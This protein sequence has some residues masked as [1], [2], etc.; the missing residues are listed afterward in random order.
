[1][2]LKEISKILKDNVDNLNISQTPIQGSAN[3]KIDNLR[4]F[5]TAI[6]NIEKTGLFKNEI[7]Q[8][9][10]TQLYASTVDSLVTHSSEY[11][12]L[13]G[14]LNIIK[15]GTHTFI[16]SINTNIPVDYSDNIVSIKLP[17]KMDLE[18]LSKIIELLKKSLSIP[19]A[20]SELNDSIEI[21][22]FESGSFWIDVLVHSTEAVGLIAAIT[23]A[24]AFINKQYLEAKIHLAYLDSLTT[25]NEHLNDL[26]EA[27]KKQLDLLVEVEAQNLQADYYNGND[28]ERI[29][30]LIF[31]IESMS[32]LIEKGTEVYP[33]L[34][35]SEN[36][37]NAFP[38]FKNLNLIESK[39]K[40]IKN[41]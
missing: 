7:Y 24:G 33:N 35:A 36:L 27:S 22:S 40:Q 9:K 13:S 26:R 6:D 39:T 4:S 3:T 1:M 37:K 11:N 41:E 38:S 17:E 19:L 8:I 34:L 12:H 20:D 21:N 15:N 2:R 14:L 25:K 16:D 32:K 10:A 23:W 30:R 29:Q 28:P 18:G 5:R 31:S